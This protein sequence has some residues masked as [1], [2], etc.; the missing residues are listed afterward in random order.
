ML[1]NARC[2]LQYGCGHTQCIVLEF[3]LDDF[4]TILRE[5]VEDSIPSS[6]SNLV[7]L[8]VLQL[9]LPGRGEGMDLAGIRTLS[10]LQCLELVA[11][12]CTEISHAFTI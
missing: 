10:A 12:G 11:P 6:I 3:A 9:D 4:S 8:T 1:R 7:S 2:H 5:G